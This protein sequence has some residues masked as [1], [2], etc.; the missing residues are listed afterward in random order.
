MWCDFK[1]DQL[2]SD[3]QLGYSFL[4]MTMPPSFRIP[5]SPVVLSLV[6]E[7][8]ENDPFHVNMSIGVVLGLV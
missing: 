6:V 1:A 8:C 3:S 4:G 2:V 5:Y 7:T